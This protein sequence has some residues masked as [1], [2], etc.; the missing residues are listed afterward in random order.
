M[1]PT[2]EGTSLVVWIGH[3]SIP[4]SMFGLTS[5]P[6][7]SRCMRA[8]CLSMRAV[9]SLWSMRSICRCPRSRSRQLLLQL[10]RKPIRFSRKLETKTPKQLFLQLI[11][12]FLA[13][14]L[15]WSLCEVSIK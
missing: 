2:A 6:Y 5:R 12:E 8:M 10:G 4:S 1:R 11:E 14:G 7:S 15:Y 3:R 9:S 13:R